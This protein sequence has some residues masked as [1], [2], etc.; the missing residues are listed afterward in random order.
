MIIQKQKNTIKNLNFKLHKYDKYDE[1]NIN[2]YEA[3]YQSTVDA[4]NKGNLDY[5]RIDDKIKMFFSYHK[6]VKQVRVKINKLSKRYN[7]LKVLIDFYPKMKLYIINK[8]VPFIEYETNRYL[9]QILNGKVIKFTVDY[10]KM[11]NKL[12]IIIYDYENKI[13]RI[14]EGWSGGERGTM[15]LSI[16]LALNKLAS[17][18]SGKNIKFLI[19]DEKFANLDYEIRNKVFE[20]LNKSLEGYISS[21]VGFTIYVTEV[22]NVGDGIIIPGDGAPYYET[23]F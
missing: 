9:G 1:S 14:Y 21:E 22:L 4:I 12:N 3:N 6:K 13:E 15:D 8:V 19:L 10:E 23:E 20:M 2:E 18:R 7:M 11:Q 16:F 5:Q 17:I